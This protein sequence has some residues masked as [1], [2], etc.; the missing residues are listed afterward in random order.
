[1][2]G[3]WG[4]NPRAHAGRDRRP[5]SRGSRTSRGFNPR[6]HAGR[7]TPLPFDAEV[8]D[9]STH[10]PTRGATGAQHLLWPYR[11]FQPTRPRG[12]RPGP[13]PPP[14]ASPE[15]QPTRPRGARRSRK[16]RPTAIW[17][18]NPRAHAGRDCGRQC[19][20]IRVRSFN[21]RAH[22][23]R[24]VT[25]PEAP[26]CC[27]A[28]QPTRPRG[29]RRGRRAGLG[30]SARFNPR[31][32]AG[33]D[34]HRPPGVRNGRRFNPRAH[35]GR[36]A[37]RVPGHGCRDVS[38]HAPT[39]GA[40]SLP[41]VVLVIA[42][43]QPTRPRG[44]RHLVGR[45]DC[46]RGSFQPTRPRGARRAPTPPQPDDAAVSTH[47]PTRG[48]TWL[49]RRASSRWAF[50][51]T[52]PRG[53]RR[54]QPEGPLAAAAVSTHA[55]TRGA[56]FRLDLA[57]RT[58]TRFNPRAHAGR[59]TMKGDALVRTCRFQPTR[60][61]GARRRAAGRS[62]VP[63]PSFNPRAHAGRDLRRGN[64][65]HGRCVSTHA[66]TRGATSPLSAPGANKG[67]QPTRPRGARW[68]RATPIWHGRPCFNPRA[69]AGRDR[70]RPW[71]TAT[72]IPVSTH[73]PTRGATVKAH[74][75]RD[76]ERVSTH[77]PTRGATQ[78]ARPVDPK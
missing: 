39:R 67:F 59:D 58:I 55:P 3:L 11:V 45:E 46:G 57:S 38:T 22:A 25:G 51:P 76:F 28:F 73:A 40:T 61:R 75:G 13:V 65:A 47:A 27:W 10:A 77:A 74:R 42:A 30:S 24:D 69:H 37:G 17:S 29:A 62:P 16:R 32:H 19:D 5:R 12:A 15:F 33:R 71:A 7:D 68:I 8:G 72:P 78:I 41:A 52:R 54:G 53:A 56:T 26:R 48:A 35:A 34:V 60:P 64:A 4:F 44:A 2:A 70:R 63:R 21:P 18:F 66:P 36:D 31:A 49:R 50:Q 23:G 20:S 43:F 14:S 1:M 9:V 6:A